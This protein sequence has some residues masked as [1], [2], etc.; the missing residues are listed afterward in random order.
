MDKD[1]VFEIGLYFSYNFVVLGESDFID[2]VAGVSK[3]KSL[4]TWKIVQ[5]K[6]PWGLVILLGG[7]FAPA[8]GSEVS[9]KPDSCGM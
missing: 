4:L 6:M 3:Q 5:Q 9:L 1:K 7:G 2:C 8:K